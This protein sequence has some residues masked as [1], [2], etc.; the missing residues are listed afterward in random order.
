MLTR[1][2][3]L[4]EEEGS[5]YVADNDRDSDVARTLK[6]LQAAAGTYRIAFGPR[7]GQQAD[8]GKRHT[9]GDGFQADAVR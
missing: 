1:R 3:V 9:K 4:V 8:D 6:P 7:A 2:G 5:T